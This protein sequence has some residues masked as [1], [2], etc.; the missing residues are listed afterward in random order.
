[1]Q[2][3]ESDLRDRTRCSRCGLCPCFRCSRR[4]PRRRCSVNNYCGPERRS[5]RTIGRRSAR[6]AKLNLSRSAATRYARSRRAP[7]G[8]NCSSSR[9]CGRGEARAAAGGM[10]RANCDLRDDR[11]ASENFLI[12]PSSFRLVTRPT[13]PI[14]PK[15][16]KRLLDQVG[17]MG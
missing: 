3:D 15:L 4:Q 6:G 2:K 9:D 11:Q 14:G 10:R 5:A 13:V 12:P 1:M 16:G 17:G 7:I 8:S